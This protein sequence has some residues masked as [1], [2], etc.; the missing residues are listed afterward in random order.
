MSAPH[1]RS[2]NIEKALIAKSNETPWR[3]DR[4]RAALEP[5]RV[6]VA[7]AQIHAMRRYANLLLQWNQNV[8][9]TSVTRPVEILERHFGE[10]M[11]AASAVPLEGGRLADVGSGAGFPGLALKII[12]P[13]LD[14][15]LIEPN[16]KKSA[17]LAEVAR[18]LELRGVE[19]LRG[20]F[21]ELQRLTPPADFITARA[22]GDLARLLRWSRRVLAEYGCVILWLG[23]EDAQEL[24]QFPGW[25][26]REPIPMPNSRRRIL[27]IGQPEA[28]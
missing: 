11:F 16:L 24:S 18:V 2:E 26:W 13:E 12:R 21:E 3:D 23:A 4:V 10:S 20:R 17:F 22:V 28:D 8:N 7:P 27:L 19:I 14:L 15:V 1:S 6:A 25:Q 5:F 9:L